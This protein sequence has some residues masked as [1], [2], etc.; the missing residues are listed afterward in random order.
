MAHWI[1]FNFLEWAIFI[2]INPLFEE[3]KQE[4]Q[5]VWVPPLLEKDE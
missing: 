1:L 5:L 2:D 3:I 4:E